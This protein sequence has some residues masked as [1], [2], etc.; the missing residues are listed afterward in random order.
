M[1]NMLFS[2]KCTHAKSFNIP[3]NV[4]N[5]EQSSQCKVVKLFCLHHII[6]GF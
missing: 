3:K 5:D 1:Y 4:D 2:E 6:C